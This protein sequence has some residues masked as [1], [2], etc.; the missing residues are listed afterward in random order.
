MNYLSLHWESARRAAAYFFKQP[1]AALMILAMLAIAM[2]LPLTLYLGVQ[3]SKNV[4]DRLSGVPQITLYMDMGAAGADTDAVQKLLA[5]DPRVKE[6]RFVAKAEGL[7]EMKAA[8]DTQEVVSMLDENPLP[9]AFVVTP[10]DADPQAVLALQKDLAA[11]PMVESTQLDQE[12]M[13]TLYRLNT[14]ANQIFWFLAITLGFAFVLVAHNTIRLQI[15]SRKEE[16][17]ITK[18]LG[19]PSSFVRRPFLYQA[20]WQSLL[21]ALLSLILCTWLMAQT[22]P[23]ITQIF[24][25]YGINLQWRTFYWWET[26]SVLI[27]VCL[28]GIAGAWAATRRHLIGFKA[29]RH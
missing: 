19:A 26:V 22:R 1:L 24:Q 21:S 16:I 23:L 29:R 18:L 11:Y 6:S 20:T 28:L 9:D 25:P 12:W 5:G 4:L 10:A 14:L 7:E 13:Q 8:M 3:S 27:V 17:E 15:L 2:T